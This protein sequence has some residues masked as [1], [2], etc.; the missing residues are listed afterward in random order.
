MYPNNDFQHGTPGRTFMNTACDHPVSLVC[1]VQRI[2]VLSARQASEFPLK[3]CQVRSVQ[4]SIEARGRSRF[5]SRLPRQES[6][7]Q[8]LQPDTCTYQYQYQ[9]TAS[10]PKDTPATSQVWKH[11]CHSMFLCSMFLCICH[12]ATPIK[13]NCS[14]PDHCTTVWVPRL[15]NIE[16]SLV[17]RYHLLAQ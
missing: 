13:C 14:L 11:K 16:Y 10:L 4:F 7:Q 5:L 8:H 17:K 15:R 12:N 1:S 2:Q 3:R 6:T 9:S